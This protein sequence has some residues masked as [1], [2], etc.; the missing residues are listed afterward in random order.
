M[1]TSKELTETGMHKDINIISLVC[2][3]DIRLVK[4]R[5][6]L[7]VLLWNVKNVII[8]DLWHRCVMGQ[9]YHEHSL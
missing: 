7:V 4:H 1:N 8:E 2:Y 6:M 3:L 5:E 9:L